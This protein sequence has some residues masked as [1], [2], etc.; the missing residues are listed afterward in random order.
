MK[1]VVK[2]GRD[3]ASEEGALEREVWVGVHFD[4]VDCE[5]IVEHEVQAVDLKGVGPFLGVNFTPYCS[6]AVGCYL[7]DLW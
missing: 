4:E 7:L 2:H 6:E 5:V 1:S 3:K